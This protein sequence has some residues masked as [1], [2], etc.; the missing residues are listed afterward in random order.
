MSFY[1]PFYACRVQV[2]I[3]WPHMRPEHAQFWQWSGVGPCGWHPTLGTC[4][5]AI[6]IAVKSPLRA[7][8]YKKEIH[9][10]V[11]RT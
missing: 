5:G 7:Y 4:L 3:V 9:D 8:T 1:V 2:T 6:Y 11:S 10:N